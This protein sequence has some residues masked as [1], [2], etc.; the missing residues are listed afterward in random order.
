MAIELWAARLERPLTQ[1]ETDAMLRMLPLERRDRLLR[2]RPEEKRR[3]PL[4]AY[5]VLRMALW[6]QYHWRELP[7]IALSD[8]G[9]PCFPGYPDVHFNIS[10]TTGAV[11]VGLSDQP[12][13]VDIEKIRPVSQRAM[14]RIAGVSTETEF[15]Q[16]WVRRE[17]R[18]KRSGVGISTMVRS[19][20]PL[21]RGEYYYEVETF[22]GY[23]AGVATRS[24]AWPGAV[25][26]YSLDEMV[27]TG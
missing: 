16:S 14:Q 7:E 10:H 25:R 23:A 4:C 6:E 26:K 19:E 24:K 17:A 3:E 1:R 13:G 2:L 15:F 21:Q 20:S 22:P 9:K 12:I 8:L 18:A 5:L 27:E 11:L